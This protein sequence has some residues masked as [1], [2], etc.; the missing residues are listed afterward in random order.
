MRP[1]KPM[2]GRCCRRAPSPRSPSTASRSLQNGR[3]GRRSEPSSAGRSW[4]CSSPPARRP[5]GRYLWF[6]ESVAAVVASTPDVKVAAKRLDVALPGQP[7]T[8][9][10]IGYDKRANE[11]KGDPSRS[12]TVMLVRADPDTKSVSLLSFPRDLYRPDPLPRPVAVRR[13]HQQRLRDVRHQG[14]ARDGPEADRPPDQLPDH[15]QLPR[16][17]PARQRRRRGVDGRR[18]AVLQ[19][20]AAATSATQRSTCSPA[21]RS[22]A[23]TR[24]STSS[25]TATPTP[26]CTG[27]RA[28]SSSCGRSRT[29]S[30]PTPARSTCRA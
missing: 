7:A 5:A 1:S 20:P 9:L 2:A 18:P 13:P 12:D 29:R 19:Q 10:V 17:P 28:S 26:T 14:H 27:S 30:G 15:G 25:V 6:H 16:L 24:H 3:A 8:A 22:S 23:A 21:T 4:R 11:A